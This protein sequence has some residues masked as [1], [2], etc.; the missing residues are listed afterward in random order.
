MKNSINLR[1]YQLFKPDAF[2]SQKNLTLFRCNMEITIE[3]PLLLIGVGKM[4]GA[5]CC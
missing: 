3:N 1:R 2:L 4:G 5:L